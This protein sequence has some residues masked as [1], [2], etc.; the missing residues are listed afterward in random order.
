MKKISIL[1]FVFLIL[2]LSF[3]V[4]ASAAT[5]YDYTIDNIKAKALDGE[6]V[7]ALPYGKFVLEATV[8]KSDATDDD[9]YLIFALYGED[10]LL[11]VVWA[12]AP[13]VKDNQ[14]TFS[15]TISAMQE[16]VFL[17]KAFLWDNDFK[18]LANKSLSVN[19]SSTS[20]A[21]VTGISFIEQ[22][23]YI[24]MEITPPADQ[25]NIISYEAIIYNKNNPAESVHRSVTKEGMYAYYRLDR[26]DIF[27]AGQEFNTVKII[28]NGAEGYTDAVWMDNISVVP[29]E[30][31][32]SITG[33]YNPTNGNYD[34]TFNGINQG[35]LCAILTREDGSVIEELYNKINAGACR[36]YNLTG[37]W[38]D[39]DKQAL[40]N[41]KV[42][43]SFT[44]MDVTTLLT[45]GGKW[46]VEFDRFT[47]PDIIV[48]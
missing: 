42:T 7:E 30:K 1:L 16:K 46:I 35:Y 32:V 19:N 9:I 40:E 29:S 26:A 28:S 17:I 48:Q 31:D 12:D 25:T 23:M 20:V 38:S 43:C 15:A 13:V 5:Q 2:I 4:N 34:I 39:E 24:K 14:L 36:L 47:A 22:G 6:E 27:A 45:D 21:P 18:P 3:A 10:K 11:N 41:G 44:G 8:S 37:D 33:A